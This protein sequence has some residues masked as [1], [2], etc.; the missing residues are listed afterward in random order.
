MG[1]ERLKAYQWQKLLQA[2]ERA[3]RSRWERGDDY[4]ATEDLL[5]DFIFD[6]P[7]QPVVRPHYLDW[8]E[9]VD[10]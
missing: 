8:E 1:D 2:T 5:R 9:S 6:R 7:N 3:I 10:D 4:K